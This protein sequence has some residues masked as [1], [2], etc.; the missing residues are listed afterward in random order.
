MGIRDFDDNSFDPFDRIFFEF[1][2]EKFRSVIKALELIG[3]FVK[4]DISL[5]RRLNSSILFSEERENNGRIEALE[6]IFFFAKISDF[7]EMRA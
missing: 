5:Y 6:L 7:C 3:I 1:E 2:K 4:H